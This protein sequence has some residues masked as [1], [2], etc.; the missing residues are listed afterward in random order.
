[1][2]GLKV[3]SYRKGTSV[4]WQHLCESVFEITS[5][6]IGNSKCPGQIEFDML[7]IILSK[8]INK[9]H[10]CIWELLLKVAHYSPEITVNGLNVFFT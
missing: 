6:F 7:V 4:Y 3:P 1:M 5:I 10:W 9:T 8:C 2:Y